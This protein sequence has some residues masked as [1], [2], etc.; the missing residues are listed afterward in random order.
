MTSKIEFGHELMGKFWPKVYPVL[1]WENGK[2]IWN[3]DLASTRSI[4][5]QAILRFTLILH[6]K[7]TPKCP[8]ITL[9]HARCSDEHAFGTYFLTG[10]SNNVSSLSPSPNRGNPPVLHMAFRSLFFVSK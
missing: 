3:L 9:Y 10:P 5:Y 4:T 1:Q 6:S 2:W 7:V 8:Q